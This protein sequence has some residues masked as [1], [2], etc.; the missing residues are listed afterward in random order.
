MT[1]IKIFDAALKL[2]GVKRLLTQTD[3][4]AEFP[5]YFNIHNILRFGDEYAKHIY[6]T[7]HNNFWK[8]IIKSMINLEKSFKIS[9]FIHI[10][11]MPIWHNSRLNFEYRKNWAEKGYYIVNDILNEGGGGGVFSQ[12]KN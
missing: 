5:R 9:I 1:N 2:S 10:Q 8:D 11:N 4:W 12:K 6:A 3:G 7:S